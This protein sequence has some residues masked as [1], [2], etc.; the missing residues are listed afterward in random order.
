MVLGVRCSN[1]EYTYCILKG[2]FETPLVE[3]VQHVAFPN[4]Y[5]E[6]EILKWLHQEFQAVFRAHTIDA[7]GIKKAEANVK[8]SNSL[9][10]R[11]QAEAIVSLTAAEV[12]CSNVSRKVKAS[13]AKGLGLKGRA[14]YL[15]SK[16]DTSVIADF[17]SYSNKE[18]EA[19]LVA[20]SCME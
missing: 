15:Q 3:N 18:Q 16:L 9:E 19:I 6:S 20:W 7:V 2:T 17:A 14:K 11:I 13:I 1:T 4:G 8:R 10:L 12:G 5:S